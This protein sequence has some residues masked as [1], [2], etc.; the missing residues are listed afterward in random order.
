MLDNVTEK[1]RKAATRYMVLCVASLVIGGIIA[2]AIAKEGG[3]E[4]LGSIGPL[5]A[6]GGVH[7]LCLPMALFHSYMQ[8]RH[9]KNIYIYLYYLLF[10][11]LSF[12]VSGPEIVGYVLLLTLLAV[13][14]ILFSIF[15]SYMRA[16]R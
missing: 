14:P 12:W 9:M 1:H 16:R 10:V 11:I 13:V 15:M 4:A 5:M 8:H 3:P 7:L 2:F 6:I